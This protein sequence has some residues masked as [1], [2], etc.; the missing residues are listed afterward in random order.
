M[1]TVQA[2][3][4]NV[5]K[6]FTL[7]NLSSV[8][9]RQ[10][11][12]KT[13]VEDMIQLSDLNE[14]SLLWNLRLRYD[15]NLIYTY[16]GS[17]LV[18]VNPYRM[19]DIYGLDTVARYENQ[20]LGTLPPHLF[21]IGKNQ[22][23]TDFVLVDKI[24]IHLLKAPRLTPGWQL[25]TRISALSSAASQGQAKL[26]GEHY[27]RLPSGF[28]HELNYFVLLESEFP[29]FSTK[30]I[31]QYLAAVNKSS[32]NLITEQ[33]L[34]ASPLL[35]SFGNAKTV[36]NDN[37]SRFGK[38]LEIFFKVSERNKKVHK[39]YQNNLLLICPLKYIFVCISTKDIKALKLLF[40]TKGRCNVPFQFI[41]RKNVIAR[42]K[43]FSL[44]TLA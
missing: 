21:A 39:L 6:T 15:S 17:I 18:A 41:I 25:C 34:E 20:V 19:F 9:I 43:Y 24:K 8:R 5:N 44:L 3:I 40:Y 35:E 7:N 42:K 33:I 4:N 29:I 14:A 12:G 10:D 22:I 37:S 31:M 23:N 2:V 26:R 36:R 16:V 38:Y 27:C 1:I 30:L 28:V 32:S 13:G 11:L